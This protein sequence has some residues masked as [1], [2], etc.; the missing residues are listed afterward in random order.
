MPGTDFFDEDLTRQRDPARRVKVGGDEAVETLGEGTGGDAPVRPVSDFNLTRMARH[1]QQVD[2]QTAAAAQELERLRK[3]QEQIEHEKRELEDLRRKHEEYDRGK[4]EI[5]DH[6]RQT[7]ASL[8][9][10][11]VDTGRLLELIGEAR[12]RFK[13]KLAEI[14]VINEEGWPEDQIRAELNRNLAFIEE[15]RM[16]YNKSMARIDAVRGEDKGAAPA[17]G[18]LLFEAHTA[19]VE[20]E[21][22]FGYWLKVGMAVSLPIVVTVVVLVILYLV[23]QSGGML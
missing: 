16:E 22:S 6:L 1:R 7:L 17:G 9:R 11:E 23:A 5:L 13:A 19:A 15:A 12:K 2:E 4:R 14:E 18:P 20:T 21:K 8:E 3:R 10:Q